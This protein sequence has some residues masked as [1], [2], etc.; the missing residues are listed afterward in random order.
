MGP[1][2]PVGRVSRTSEYEQNRGEKRFLKKFLHFVFQKVQE[3]PPC[4]E[5]QHL[6]KPP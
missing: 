5:N 1:G 2:C 6:A 3:T 4:G